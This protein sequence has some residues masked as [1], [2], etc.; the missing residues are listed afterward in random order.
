MTVEA[1]HDDGHLDCGCSSRLLYVRLP[2]ICSECHRSS[3]CVLGQ[4][5]YWPTSAEPGEVKEI[6]GNCRSCDAEITWRALV[7]R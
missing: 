4:R 6:V 1:A 7:I 5:F 3:R 2:A